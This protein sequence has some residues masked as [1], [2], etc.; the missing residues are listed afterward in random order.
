MFLHLS[1]SHS[2]HGGCLGRCPP[3]QVHPRAG[4][5]WSRY[6]PGQVPPP[7]TP[8]FGQ[9]PLHRQVHPLAGTPPGRYPTPPPAGTP[10]GPGTPPG[11][12]TYWAGTP[13]PGRYKQV[14]PLAG[15]PPPGRYT[16]PD[17]RLLL[18]TVRILLE[19]ILFCVFFFQTFR[20]NYFRHEV[21]ALVHQD[22]HPL[23]FGPIF[24]FLCRFWEQLPSPLKV[25][26][27]HSPPR[28]GKS[29][30]RYFINPGPFLSVCSCYCFKMKF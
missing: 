4:A 10:P 13:P 7:G 17:R 6:T 21:I 24:F 30:I 20:L 22:R 18:R 16:P 2:V 11:R 28:S 8:L 15:T 19:C 5:P 23:P 14:H 27:P 1:V 3:E 12:Y 29:W 25:T 26:S 9:V